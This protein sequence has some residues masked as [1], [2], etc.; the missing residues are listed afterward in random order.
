[1]AFVPTRR[2]MVHQRLVVNGRAQ[3][4][5]GLNNT[6]VHAGAVERQRYAAV[7]VHRDD[8]ARPTVRGQ[9]VH[10]HALRSLRQSL[11]GMAHPGGNFMTGGIADK[12]LAIARA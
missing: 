2:L 8:A 5:I 6:A 4:A 9:Q 7:S 12:D 11:P 10:H 1:M 3:D